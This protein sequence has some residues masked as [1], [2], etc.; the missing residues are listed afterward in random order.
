MNYRGYS[1]DRDKGHYLVTGPEGMWTEDTV[2]D[3]KH[4]IDELED[5][6]DDD[7]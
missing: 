2:D 3:A 7:N 1:I 6:V 5:T 4:S